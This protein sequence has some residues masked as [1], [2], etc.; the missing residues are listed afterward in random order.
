MLDAGEQKSF[1]YTGFLLEP[2][3]GFRGMESVRIGREGILWKAVEESNE[4]LIKTPL[5]AYYG[6]EE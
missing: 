2:D 6:M 1:A 5:T 3:P 4:H